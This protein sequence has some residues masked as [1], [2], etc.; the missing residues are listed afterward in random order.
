MILIFLIIKITG[1]VRNVGRKHS[2]ITKKSFS[3]MIWK[4]GNRY[5]ISYN[6]LAKVVLV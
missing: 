3:K 1:Q 2:K 5:I 6:E 4:F